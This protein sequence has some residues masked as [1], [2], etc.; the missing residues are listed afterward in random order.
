MKKVFVLSIQHTGT[1]FASATIS[2][3]Y[4]GHEK[5]RV[6]SLYEKHRNLKHR[7]YTTTSPI[8]L[9]D[10][11]K[12]GTKINEAWFDQAILSACPQESLSDKKIVVGH[13]HH[14]KAGSWLIKSLHQNPAETPIIIPMRD[15]LLSLHSKLWREEEQYNK[16]NKT[17]DKVRINRLESWI[18]RYYE[19]LS[20]PQS[21]VF[22][23][24]IDAKQST[25]EESRIILI[26]DMYNYCN[27]DF[28]EK[29]MQAALDWKP[30]NR[31][32]NLIKNKKEEGPQPKWEDFK[33]KYLKGDINH[34]RSFMSLEFDRLRQEDKLKK[35]MEKIGYENVLW[36]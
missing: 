32:F 8:E 12:P 36:W 2:A 6:G 4:E 34:T 18:E 13:E 29:A 35:L 23:L 14:H 24:P 9:S 26:E 22:I 19:I 27:I 30:A 33:S 3:G 17:S 11:S 15:P 25:A 28:N 5:L 16:T 31:T 20:L 7:R 10:F 21:H 1:F